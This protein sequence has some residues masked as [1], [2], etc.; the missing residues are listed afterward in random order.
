[1]RIIQKKP[2]DFL[3]L[4]GDD[5]L[6]LPMIHMGAEGVIS[7]IGQSHP[8]DFSDMVLFALSGNNKRANQIHYRLYDFY[9]PLYEEG[10]PVGIK[11]CLELLKICKSY[12]RLPLVKASVEI[13]RQLNILLD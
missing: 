7:V 2:S 11:A 10:N 5:S 6:T 4:S 12:V 1:M 13:K 9:E 3:V 8:K